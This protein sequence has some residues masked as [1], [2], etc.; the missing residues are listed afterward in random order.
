MKVAPLLKAVALTVSLGIAGAP[1][2]YHATA[3]DE[4][5]PP[6]FGPMPESATLPDGSLDWS[7]MPEY[8]PVLAPDGET[9]AGYVKS[10]DLLRAPP[11]PSSPEAAEFSSLVEHAL[12][13]VDLSERVVGK[14]YPVIGYLSN[15]EISKRGAALGHQI[16]TAAAERLAKARLASRAPN[17]GT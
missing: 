17:D 2:I 7:L 12:P 10:D 11:A 15:A 13:V 14:F 5:V 6:K 1:L 3:E 8:I 9:V 16:E 4:P